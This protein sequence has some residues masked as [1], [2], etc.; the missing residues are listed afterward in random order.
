MTRERADAYQRVM[1][2]LRELGPSKLAAG[3]QERI[4]E[5]VDSLLFATSLDRDPA[6]RRALADV[7]ELIGLLIDSGRWEAST[8]LRLL[9]DIAACG[10]GHSPVLEAA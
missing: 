6:A 7:R 5:A 10:P 8:A 3:E 4:R 9:D 1:Q 2:T